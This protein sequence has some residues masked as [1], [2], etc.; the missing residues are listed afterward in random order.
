LEKFSSSGE[1]SK[2]FLLVEWHLLLKGYCEYPNSEMYR[3]WP[4]GHGA[5]H[6]RPW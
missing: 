5:V 6:R 4:S 3:L 1:R 2:L